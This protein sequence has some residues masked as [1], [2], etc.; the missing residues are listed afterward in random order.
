[1]IFYG[2]TGQFKLMNEISD[3]WVCAILDDYLAQTEIVDKGQGIPVF[4]GSQLQEVLKQFHPTH[5]CVTVA[6]P[7]AQFRIN[8]SKELSKVLIPI[9]LIHRKADISRSV[10]QGYGLQVSKF[11]C[12]GP[13]V[14]IGDWCILNSNC[15]IEHDCILKDGVEIGPSA[16]LCGN[17]TVD[18]G[19]WIGAGAV[20]RQRI[21][22]GMNSVVGCGAVV[23]KDV[24]NNV[25]VV[26]N[27][28]HELRGNQ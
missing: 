25:I 28:A 11:A 12:V 8:K 20:I 13:N 10:S 14:S 15:N 19:S 7:H 18:E 4:H 5:F 17:V 26:G 21:S 1:M 3:H 23:V 2:G 27:P 9:S 6:N 24:P 22:I 16:T